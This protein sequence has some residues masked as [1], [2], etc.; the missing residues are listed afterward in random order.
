MCRGKKTGNRGVTVVESRIL[1]VNARKGTGW[2]GRKAWEGGKIKDGGKSMNL[3]LPQIEKLA[4]RFHVCKMTY[5]IFQDGRGRGRESPAIVVESRVRLFLR[6]T[7]FTSF[8]DKFHHRFEYKIYIYIDI[9]P[10]DSIQT[11][12]PNFNNFTVRTLRT[13]T[14]QELHRKRRAKR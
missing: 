1:R 6:V 8:V 11:E 3:N 13:Y 14:F 2:K 12:F 4:P 9:V 7:K 5:T 10:N